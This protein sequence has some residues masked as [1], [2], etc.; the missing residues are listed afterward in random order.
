VETVEFCNI[1]AGISWTGFP[2]ISGK[3]YDRCGTFLNFNYFLKI[4]VDSQRAV[5]ATL[6]AL[7]H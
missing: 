7:E 1:I 6:Q 4:F 2:V 5:N 3:L